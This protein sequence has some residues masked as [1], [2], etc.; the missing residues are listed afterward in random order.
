MRIIAAVFA[1]LMMPVALVV[2]GFEIALC[3]IESKLDL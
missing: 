2:V 1:W 3:W